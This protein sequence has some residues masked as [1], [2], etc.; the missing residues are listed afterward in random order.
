MRV[1]FQADA[2]LNQVIVKAT[3]RREPGV[4]FATVQAAGLSGLND[5]EVLAIAA[6]S[7]RVLVTHD[8]KSMPRQF[9]SFITTHTRAGVLV[10]PQ[11]IAISQAVEEL[12][13]VWNASEAEEWVNRILCLPL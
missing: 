9:A 4:N 6:A 1:R 12:L 2:D 7:S 3:L 5:Q 10:V 11:K 8:R 13:L